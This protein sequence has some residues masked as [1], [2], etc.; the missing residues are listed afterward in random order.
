[1]TEKSG[2]ILDGTIL[3]LLSMAFATYLCRIGGVWLMDHLP[4]SPA[5]KRAL[6]A[7]PGSIIMAT[8]L[9]LGM[10]GGVAALCGLA[11]TLG[12]MALTRKD[13]AALCSGMAVVIGLRLSGF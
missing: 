6:Q 5:L 1:M 8:I 7:L 3:A 12:V 2:L 4:P 10:Q 9:P 13:L 11:A